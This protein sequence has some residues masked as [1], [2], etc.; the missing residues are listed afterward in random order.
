MHITNTISALVAA[1]TLAGAS[2]AQA[3]PPSSTQG[4]SPL[5]GKLSVDINVGALTVITV[6]QLPQSRCDCV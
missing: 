6:G 3:Q 2:L 4:T 1:F 5:G